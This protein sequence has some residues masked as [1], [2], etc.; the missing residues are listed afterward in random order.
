[1]FLGVLLFKY[2]TA[3]ELELPLS[4]SVQIRDNKIIIQ[5]ELKL[6]ENYH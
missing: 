2:I 1:M 4:E 6:S 3:F 5:N